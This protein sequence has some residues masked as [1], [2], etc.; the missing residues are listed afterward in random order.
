[1]GGGDEKED[2]MRKGRGQGTR[3]ERY[4]MENGDRGLDSLV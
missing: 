2:R 3:M 1:M 4:C